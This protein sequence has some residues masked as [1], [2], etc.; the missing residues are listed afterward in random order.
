MNSNQIRRGFL[1][2]F[3][4]RGHLILPSAPL[5]P[6]RDPTTL[7]KRDELRLRVLKGGSPLPGLSV[8]LVQA[9]QKKPLMRKTD[10]EGRVRF[11]LALDGWALVRA[12]HLVHVARP[13]ADWESHFATLT[14]NVR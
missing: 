10:R 13:D 7:R 2:Y 5:V 14:L 1:D 9:G 12:T 4:D 3:A 11:P 6:E 8:G